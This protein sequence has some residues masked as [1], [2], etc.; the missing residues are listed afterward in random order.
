MGD[1]DVARNAEVFRVDGLVTGGVL[2]YGVGVYAG[3]VME[4]S[5]SRDGRVEG[6][7]DADPL[8][9]QVLDFAQQGQVV[10]AHELRV[11]RVDAGHQAPQRRDAIAFADAQH[12]RIDVRRAGLQGAPGVGD[13]A[14]AV[15]VAMKLDVAIDCLAQTADQTV[16][17]QGVGDADRIRHADAIDA[18]K[19][20]R[21]VDGEHVRQVAA[22][23]VF[24]A[25]TRLDAPVLQPGDDFAAAV[26][27]LLQAAPMAELPHVG[28]GADVDVHA[29]DTAIHRKARLVHARANVG[30]QAETTLHAG[31]GAQR[32]LALGA[33]QRRGQF[34]VFHAKGVQRRGDFQFVR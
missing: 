11:D 8:R 9:H 34:H 19:V 20:H 29:I 2:Q 16:R 33:G 14:A 24:G 25:K 30:Q 5:A 12:S 26:D 6:H 28:R 17:A 4:G 18:G 23:G 3:L 32:G 21:A 1:V 31:D 7:V 15:I 13:R 10:L 27:D 22:E